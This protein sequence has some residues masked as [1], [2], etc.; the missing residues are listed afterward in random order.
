MLS[1]GK[2]VYKR[3]IVKSKPK[4]DKV[5]NIKKSESQVNLQSPDLNILESELGFKISHLEIENF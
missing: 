4:L 5:F 1:S 3:A 2:V